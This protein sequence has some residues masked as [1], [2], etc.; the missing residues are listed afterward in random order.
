VNNIELQGEVSTT[1][2]V[3][4]VEVRDMMSGSSTAEKPA[5]TEKTSSVTPTAPI[6]TSVPAPAFTPAAPAATEAAPPTVASYTMEQVAQHSSEP[7]C[8]TAI[9]VNVYNVTAFINEHPGG[10]RNILKICGIDGSAAFNRQH[11][12][13]TDPNATLGGFIIG[14]LKI[15][16][17]K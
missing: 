4:S 5:A 16:T 11:A 8:W 1:T 6:V 12:V 2:D 13:K 9:N 10:D 3:E 15:G 17:L 7:D 14:T